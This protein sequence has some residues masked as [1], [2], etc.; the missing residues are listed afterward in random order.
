MSS[1]ED[2]ANVNEEPSFVFDPESIVEMAF[3]PQAS[4]KP[5]QSIISSGR[6]RKPYCAPAPTRVNTRFARHISSKSLK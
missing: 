5:N 2:E 3:D 1:T 4:L 6:P